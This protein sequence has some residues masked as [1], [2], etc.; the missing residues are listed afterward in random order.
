MQ[1][2]GADP[3]HI[4]E[5]KNL[6]QVSFESELEPIVKKV[7]KNN[8]KAVEDYKEGKEQA[9]KFLI[10]QVMRESRG[11]ANPQVVKKLLI[12]FLASE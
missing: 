9:L 8:P 6:R 4:I 11:K 5:K 3:S 1:K 12:N 10:G 7:T 2:T